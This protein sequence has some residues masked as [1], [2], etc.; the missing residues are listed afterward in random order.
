MLRHGSTWVM[1]LGIAAVA[2]GILDII[3]FWLFGGRFLPPTLRGDVTLH[4]ALAM[5][6]LG[7]LGW[8][9][10]GC[11]RNLEKRLERLES[12]QGLSRDNRIERM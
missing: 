8:I 7:L 12:S 2:S 11:L 1:V 4:V 3:Q 6:V 9:I 5:V 10:G